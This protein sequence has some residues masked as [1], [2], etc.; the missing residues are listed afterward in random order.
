MQ[1]MK[2]IE[3]LFFRFSVELFR[4]C[5]FFL[6]YIIS[7]ILSF[8]LYNVIKYRRNVVFEN[9]K[10]SFPNKTDKELKSL[11]KSFYKHLAD[12]S[13]ESV[14][15]MTISK[16]AIKK[17]Y[18]VK[19]VNIPNEYYSKSQSI[20]CLTSHYGNWEYGILGTD[21]AIKHQAIALYLPLSNKYTESYGIKRRRRFG[22]KMVAVQETKSIF[23]KTPEVPVAV[24]MAADQ[25]PSNLSKAIWT[26]FL[27]RDT[28]CLHGPE[29]YAKKI[30][31][32]VLFLSIK[33]V[34]RGYYELH[35]EK[36]IDNPAPLE[37]GK[38]TKLY[39]ERLE[40]D[41]V[42]KPDFYL[43]SHRRWKHKKL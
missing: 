31:I 4:F 38:I 42:N 25:S 8:V 24:I 2:Y 41:I 1:N 15:G 20:L 16:K 28:A 43:W 12:I 11:S 29:A 3:Y 17:R 33:K 5:P 26:K 22:M 37:A 21:S 18:K 39:M 23:E 19:H 27:N 14:K 32:P 10:N 7:D 34:K 6:L 30:N 13:L 9:L 35:F 40:K 36:F